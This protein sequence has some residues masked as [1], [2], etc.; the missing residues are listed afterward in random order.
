MKKIILSLSA[1]LICGF[2]NAQS[3]TRQSIGSNGSTHHGEDITIQQCIGQPYQTTAYYSNELEA[4]PGFIQPTK[5]SIEFVSSTFKVNVSVFP[6]PTAQFLSFQSNENLENIQLVVF[7][8][9]GS[10]VH[11][12]DV[13][14]LNSFILDCSAF[15][16]GTYYLQLKDHANSYNSKFIISK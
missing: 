7:D 13:D 11:T 16:S 8:Q 5:M 1:L 15:N 12:I 9:K 6:N 4:R 14:H 2:A 10:L 3:V